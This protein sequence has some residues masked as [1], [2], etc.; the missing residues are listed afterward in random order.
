MDTLYRSDDLY[1]AWYSLIC[2]M[3][4]KKESR[5]FGRLSFVRYSENYF[6]VPV[7]ETFRA[8][9]NPAPA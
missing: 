5:P 2:F 9:P 4:S 8:V 7:T 1:S 3:R 6:C